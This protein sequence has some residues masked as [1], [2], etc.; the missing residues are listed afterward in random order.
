M[1]IDFFFLDAAS[2][3]DAYSDI[4]VSMYEKLG[5][6]GMHSCPAFDNR[7]PCTQLHRT[8]SFQQ[9]MEYSKIILGKLFNLYLYNPARPPKAK[10]HMYITYLS[11]SRR[12]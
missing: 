7:Q 12:T 5:L 11:Y 6:V 1:P 9:V 2:A 3:I 10:P 4:A 8:Y